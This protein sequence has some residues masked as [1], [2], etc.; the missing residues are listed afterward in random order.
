MG[1][2]SVVS[3]LERI[4]RAIDK[5]DED[6]AEWERARGPNILASP[7][8]ASSLSSKQAVSLRRVLSVACRE[9]GVV[10]RFRF[11]P[12]STCVLGFQIRKQ[13]DKVDAEDEIQINMFGMRC[14]VVQVFLGSQV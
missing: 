7:M 11:Q 6:D 13:I 4:G 1:L 2:L 5:E 8:L 3:L 10:S 14:E 9:G 12:F